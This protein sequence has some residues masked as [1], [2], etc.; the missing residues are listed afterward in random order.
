VATNTVTPPAGFPQLT[1]IVR[2]GFVVVVLLLI[3][4]GVGM[5]VDTGRA[6]VPVKAQADPAA[7]EHGAFT[8]M[9]FRD[10]SVIQERFG[11]GTSTPN[12][13]PDVA[14]AEHGA[15]TAMT[16]RDPS[17]I[18]ERFGGGTSTPNLDPDVIA[19]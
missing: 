6:G 1:Q 13:D 15:F 2:Q 18:Q 17:V 3:G 16:F 11:G 9:T 10:P 5:A 19:P 14:A 7:A 12:L 4:V 8:A